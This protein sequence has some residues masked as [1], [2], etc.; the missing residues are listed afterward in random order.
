[1]DFYFAGLANQTN[2]ID[3]ARENNY[4]I[5]CSYLRERKT[6]SYL[7]NFNEYRG[8]LLLDSGAFSAW[9]QGVDIDI[10][11]YIE[12]INEYDD[13]I[14]LY[15][16]L[17][18]IPGTRYTS[19]T[20]DEIVYATNKT[21]DNFIYMRNR[22]KSPDKLIVTY[23]VGEPIDILHKILNYEDE[24]GKIKYMALGGLVSKSESL[25]I[26]FIDKCLSI[27]KNS[28]NKNIGVHAFGLTNRRIVEKF[29]LT[30]VD[31]STSIMTA[32][33]G[34]V[35][36]NDRQYVI[37]DSSDNKNINIMNQ[38]QEV[39]NLV[40]SHVKNRGYTLES[41]RTSRD[42][43]ILFNMQDFESWYNS[44]TINPISVRK[45]ELF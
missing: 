33:M 12:F 2:L 17:D 27:I 6:I 24:F 28:K 4:N 19:P 21:W 29:N 8:K 20:S 39:I 9:T 7:S 13:F 41:L 22:V 35:I 5:L 25:A 11:N 31:S 38:S 40:E 34:K 37:S 16:S 18:V 3:F 43:R 15:A 32:A 42:A 10:D 44:F 30:S 45:I 23:H 1:M 36:I 14:D 26:D